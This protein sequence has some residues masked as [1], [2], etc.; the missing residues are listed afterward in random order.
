MRWISVKAGYV[1]EM[2]RD[3]ISVQGLEVWCCVGVPD[4]ERAHPQRLKISVSFSAP[5]VAQA[6]A[7]DDLSHTI[8]YYEVSREVLRVAQEKPRRLIETLAEDLATALRERFDLQ[9]V[10]VEIHKFIIPACDAVV[11][12]IHRKW[13]GE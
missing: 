6:A 12:R 11:L 10:D 13:E 8:N 7:A 4:E 1:V 2:N 3:M 9:S 5:G